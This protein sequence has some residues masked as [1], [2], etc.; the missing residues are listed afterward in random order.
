[1]PFPTANANKALLKVI[2][3][4]TAPPITKFDNAIGYPAKTA[5]KLSSAFLLD[6]GTDENAFS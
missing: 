3:T 2:P 4:P 6:S 1:M 5:V